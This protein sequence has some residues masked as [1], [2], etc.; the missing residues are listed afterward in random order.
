MSKYNWGKDVLFQPDAEG[1]E[2]RKHVLELSPTAYPALC[3]QS[4]QLSS[5]L[6]SFTTN[7]L[8]EANELDDVQGCC[9]SAM[10]LATCSFAV[11]VLWVE[12]MTF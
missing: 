9:A 3:E 6:K 1:D 2:M 4:S 5:Q 10:L 11:F 7:K 8:A 12:A